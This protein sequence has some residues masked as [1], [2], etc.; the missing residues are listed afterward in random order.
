M[1]RLGKVKSSVFDPTNNSVHRCARTW[2]MAVGIPPS[3]ILADGPDHDIFRAEQY[4]GGYQQGVE[5]YTIGSGWSPE[6]T[7]IGHLRLSPHALAAQR[8]GFL[9]RLQHNLKAVRSN[10]HT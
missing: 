4:D 3:P 2:R 7:L 9:F 5:I 10:A 1:T 6:Y 8:K